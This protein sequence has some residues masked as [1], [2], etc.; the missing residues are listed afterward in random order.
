MSE[1]RDPGTD[2]K[3][4]TR[5]SSGLSQKVQHSESQTESQWMSVLFGCVDVSRELSDTCITVSSHRPSTTTPTTAIPNALF[6]QDAASRS[7]SLLPTALFLRICSIWILRANVRW[8]STAA[9]TT[10]ACSRRDG[11]MAGALGR[12]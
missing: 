4:T 12:W 7:H 1:Q 9:A 10:A 8:A 5:S 3:Y 11:P 2:L 6:I